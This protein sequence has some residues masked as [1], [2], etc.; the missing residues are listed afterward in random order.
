MLSVE[1]VVGTH[2][3][4]RSQAGVIKHVDTAWEQGG[5]KLLEM[6]TKVKGRVVS[7]MLGGAESFLLVTTAHTTSDGIYLSG[8]FLGCEDTEVEQAVYGTDPV[9]FH[10]CLDW[11]NC[12]KDIPH[13]DCGHFSD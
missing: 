3:K 12:D 11:E 10:C 2:M 4:D 9:A 6:G 5:D 1:D 8:L 7:M 13:G